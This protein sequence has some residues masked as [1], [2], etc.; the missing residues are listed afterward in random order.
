[1][2]Q[3]LAVESDKSA[4]HFKLLYVIKGFQRETDS[5]LYYLKH[6]RGS[7]FGFSNL[8]FVIFSFKTQRY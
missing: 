4:T 6:Y 5:D 1:M 7:Y 3:S 2:K 8:N